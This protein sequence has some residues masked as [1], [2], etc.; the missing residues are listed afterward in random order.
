MAIAK[1]DT[2]FN[3]RW[4]AFWLDSLSL[5]ILVFVYITNSISKFHLRKIL[6]EKEI[7]PIIIILIITEAIN[8]FFLSKYPYVSLSDELRDGGLFAMKIASGVVKNIFAYGTYDSHGLIIPTLVVPFYYIFGS[9]VLTYRFPAALLSSVDILLLYLLIR[10]VLNKQTAFWSAIILVSLPLHIFFAHTQVVVA[11]N[12]F[13]V[14]VILLLLYTLLKK[15]RFIDYIFLGTILGFSSG[16]HP[17]I[18]AFACLILLVLLFL[19]FKEIIFKL[20]AIDRKI[21]IRFTKVILLLFFAVVGFGPRLFFTT[22]QDFFHT[23][24]FVLQDKIETS[25]PIT[26]DD[27]TTI[28]N[29]YMKSLMVYFYEPT[30][31]FYPDHKPILSPFLAIFFVLGIGYSFF[32]LKNYFLNILLFILL[33]LPF[34]NSAITD[35]VNADHR[36]SPLFAIASV[37][38]AIGISF[39][40]ALPKNKY[41]K[42][43]FGIVILIYLLW[44]VIT[45]YSNQPSNQ[46]VELRDYLSMHALYFLQT[47][48]QYQASP[49]AYLQDMT[50]GTTQS[51]VCI[52]ASPA[53]YQYFSGNSAIEEQQEYLLPNASIQFMQE[54]SI[55]DNEVYIVKASC[56]GGNNY[57]SATRSSIT[58]CTTDNQFICPL[59]YSGNITL[60]Y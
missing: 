19:D 49:S 30:T 9:S 18:R 23:S 42:Y 4:L 33:A 52:Y 7:N 35:S 29:N 41:W 56:T 44:Q 26:F 43:L 31:F 12:F 2:N 37:F 48:K 14:P 60:H 47:D 51:P 46:N 34:I 5:L 21:K 55:D 3:Y 16:F 28:E 32:V 13:W 36:L 17:A 38:V 53:N 22:P 59:N 57:K 25:S 1:F 54:S 6:S 40:L 24:R 50:L 20:F 27:L 15:H 10:I 39:C 58:T 8:F 11:F 45:F